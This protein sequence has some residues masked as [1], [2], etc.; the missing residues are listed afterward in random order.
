MKRWMRRW[1]DWARTDLLPVYRLHR[2]PY[3]VRVRY[4]SLGQISSDLPVPWTADAVLLEVAMPLPTVARRKADFT[5]LFP[6]ASPIPAELIRSEP[7][8]RYLL[9]F[10]IVSP[11]PGP[12]ATLHWRGRAICPVRIPL[13]SESAFLAGLSLAAPTVGVRLAGQVVVAREFVATR[14]QGLQASAML[15]SK[16]RLAP[17]GELG[18]AVAFQHLPS[19]WTTTVPIPLTAEQQAATE[20]LITAVCPRLPRR[21]G[22]WRIAWRI[23][24][25]EWAVKHLEAISPRAF[26]DSLRVLTTRFAVRDR[27]G[28]MQVH[29]HLPPLA[30]VGQLG[31]CF[32]VHSTRPGAAGVCNLVVHSTAR[33]DHRSVHTSQHTLLVTDAPTL[34]APGFV[35]VGELSLLAEFGLWVNGRQLSTVSLS[36][37]P[38]ACYTAEGGYKPPPEFAW[39]AAAE[40]ELLQRLSRLSGAT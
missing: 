1:L 27:T 25:T 11:L 31:P 33:G 8:G 18:L 34:L 40:E 21:I 5:L 13:V 30:A 3:S 36:P 20:T 7:D 10:R 23:A 38:S 12:Q 16:Y 4:E 35:P 17:L 29:S 6:E 28:H 39:T 9:G 2:S 32:V 24:G 22:T 26:E 14:C 19:G 15:R 37:V